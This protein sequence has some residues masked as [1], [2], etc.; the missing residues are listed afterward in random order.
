MAAESVSVPAVDI[1]SG[2]FKYVLIEVTGAPANTDASNK[3][4]YLVRGNTRGEYHADIFEDFE[5]EFYKSSKLR[6]VCV[7]GGRIKHTP[8]KKHIVV[9]GYSQGFGRAD[10]SVTCKV[11]KTKYPDYN[12]EWNNEGY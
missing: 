5:S 1:D 6:A 11:L 8:A 3:C 2:T 4:M 12:I 10:H 9:Y 7:G